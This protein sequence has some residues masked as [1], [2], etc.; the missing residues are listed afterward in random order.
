ML[1]TAGPVA[2]GAAEA[3]AGHGLWERGCTKASQASRAP[4]QKARISGSAEPSPCSSNISC[5]TALP[6]TAPYLAGGQ[7]ARKRRSRHQATASAMN[8]LTERVNTLSD[9]C[10]HN[11]PCNHV[12]P[13]KFAEKNNNR[14]RQLGQPKRTSS[15]AEGMTRWF[16][17]TGGAPCGRRGGRAR[18]RAAGARPAPARTPAERAEPPAGRHGRSG[19][20]ARQIWTPSRSRPPPSPPGAPLQHPAAPSPPAAGL[21]L[22]PAQHDALLCEHTINQL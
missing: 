16:V 20:P 2:A 8:M 19:G 3:A 12:K 22:L 9:N 4:T 5:F 21:P 14:P 11:T 18:G 13:V 1:G 17:S 15:I 10:I 6:L 7:P